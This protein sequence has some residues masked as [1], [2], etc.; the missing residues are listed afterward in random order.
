MKEN[1]KASQLLVFKPSLS[2]SFCAHGRKRG[3]NDIDLTGDGRITRVKDVSLRS[4]GEYSSEEIHTRIL[5]WPAETESEVIQ[6]EVIGRTSC[7]L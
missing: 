6:P 3:A 7:S 5:F 2:I 1:C 4:R